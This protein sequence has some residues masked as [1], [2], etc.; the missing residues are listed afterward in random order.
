MSLPSGRSHLGRSLGV[1]A[2]AAALTSSCAAAL[3]PPRVVRFASLDDTRLDGHF[4]RPRG[5]GRH[6]AIVFLHGCGGL[7]NSRGHIKSREADWASRLMAQGYVVLMVD[8]FSPRGIGGMCAPARFDL[9]VYLARP[10]DAYGALRYLQAQ[11]FVRPD[12]IGIMGWSQGG[13]V[14][15]NAIRKASLGRPPELPQGDFRA[16]VAFYPASCRE[17][18]HRVPWT[19]T[20]PLLVLVGALDVWTPA[21]PCWDPV[22]KAAGRGSV[23]QVHVYPVAYHDFDWPGLPVHP[24]PGYRT[25][26]GVV[27][28]AGTDPAARD[29]ALSR[30]PAFLGRYLRD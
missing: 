29:D 2:L 23:A 16:A 12:R 15:L 27:P 26:R 6:P 1:I 10:K 3:V 14:I 20:I 21:E 24:L 5:E 28:I 25:S 7:I 22:E 19:S 17:G 11:E 4:F 13:G 30:V 8:S 9:T 18:A